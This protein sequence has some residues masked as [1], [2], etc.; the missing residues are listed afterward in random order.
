M[1]LTYKKNSMRIRSK[2]NSPLWARLALFSL[3]LGTAAYASQGI[4]QSQSDRMITL[5][6][7]KQ[8]ARNITGSEGLPVVVN[9]QV[10]NE[11]N[12][13]LSSPSSRQGMREALYRMKA[14]Y[15]SV[16]DAKLSEYDLPK[17][18]D[19]VPLIESK[20]ENLS[21]RGRLQVA[22]LWQFIPA[23]ARRMGIPVHPGVDE[24]M[25]IEKLSDAAGRLIKGNALFYNNLGLSLLA[26]NW[27]ETAVN[28][29]LGATRS[30][31]PWVLSQANN[32]D[33]Y[34]PQLMA[35]MIVIANPKLVE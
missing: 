22:G 13:Y 1:L 17:A 10:V 18:L 19:A 4:A 26:F 29:W 11:L 32:H 12:R 5:D 23:T 33:R 16:V 15:Q 7:A 21:A 31:D 9:D 34:L 27:G 2:L 6:E 14:K 25:N 8:L 30:R 35:G 3:L 20:Y 28:H 24:R